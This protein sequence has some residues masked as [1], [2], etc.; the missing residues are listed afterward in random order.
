MQDIGQVPLTLLIGSYAQKWHL[1]G[2]VSVTDRVAGWR[3]HAP[4]VF[5][6]PHPSWRN[7]GWI[8]KNPWFETDL[9]PALRAQVQVALAIAEYTD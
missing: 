6:L 5:T 3:D 7:T 8:K 1:G 9:L 2:K 4:H